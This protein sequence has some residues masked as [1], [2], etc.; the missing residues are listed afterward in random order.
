MDGEALRQATE[1]LGPVALGIGFLAG[2]A[3]S[4]NP[5]ALAAI[6]V[7]LAY[8]TRARAG[9]PTPCGWGRRSSSG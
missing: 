9:A 6:P 4:V 1:A 2:L 7:S 5:I 3:F 8:V